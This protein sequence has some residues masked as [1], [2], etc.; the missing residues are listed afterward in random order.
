[1][2]LKIKKNDSSKHQE[3]VNSIAWTVNNDLYSISD[4]LVINKWDS[5]TCQN[6]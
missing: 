4:D 2:R 3:M 6:N 1:M 5:N